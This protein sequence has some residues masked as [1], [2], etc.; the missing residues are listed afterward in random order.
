MFYIDL[1]T[2]SKTKLIYVFLLT[3]IGQFHFL[4]FFKHFHI[5]LDLCSWGTHYTLFTGTLI[6]GFY[7]PMSNNVESIF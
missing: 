6:W 2:F 1:E 5:Y 4:L 7:H 3:I